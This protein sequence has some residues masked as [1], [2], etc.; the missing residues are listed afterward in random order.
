MYKG[1]E[2]AKRKGFITGELEF[3]IRGKIHVIEKIEE[4]K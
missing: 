3:W 4:N 2:S 1:Y